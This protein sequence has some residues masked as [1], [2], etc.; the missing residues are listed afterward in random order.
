MPRA[1]GW[2]IMN[3]KD[4]ARNTFVSLA[5]FGVLAVSNFV[6]NAMA[7]RFLPFAEYTVFTSFFYFLIGFS[8]PVNSFQ[9]AVAKYTS[10]HKTDRRTADK[11]IMPTLAVVSLALI[12]LFSALAPFLKNFFQ[13]QSSLDFIL[14]G[15]VVVFWL[16][17]AGFRG[18]RQGEMDF[19]AYGSNMGIEGLVRAVVGI[20]LILAGFGLRGALGVSLLSGTVGVILLLYDNLGHYVRRVPHFKL[21]INFQVLREFLKALAALLPF[22]ILMSLDLNMVSW[23]LKDNPSG[24]HV[25]ACGVIG[26][27][28]ITLSLVVANVVFSY[29]LKH[30]EK[31]FWFGLLITGFTFFLAWVFVLLFGDWM[32]VFIWG[33][34]YRPA[35]QLL[36]QYILFTL[37]LGIM[38]NIINFS[39][40]RDIKPVTI[41]IWVVLAAAAAVYAVV[42]PAGSLPVFFMWGGLTLLAADIVLILPIIKRTAA[43]K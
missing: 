2:P 38:Q 28:L 29:T 31:T 33:Q 17:L 40:A 23:F 16:A 22:G 11:E 18:V 35:A 9:L 26:K 36:P 30:V 39:L 20:L 5:G 42:L 32:V 19:F 10:A 1:R 27:N 4:F 13:L 7:G 3:N 6:F 14:G 15:F 21:H 24:S 41:G 37:P 43:R 12:L 25:A 34:E 8:Q